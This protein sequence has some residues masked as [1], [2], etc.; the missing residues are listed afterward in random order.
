MQFSPT[1]QRV[2]TALAAKFGL[3]LAGAE[4]HLRIELGE[5]MMPLVIEVLLPNLLSVAHY[6]EQNGDLIAD[7]DVE[8]VITVQGWAPT[9]IRSYF[10]DRSYVN[11]PRGQADLAAFCETWAANIEAQGYG[12]RGRRSGDDDGAAGVAVAA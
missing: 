8:F 2:I 1:M 5:S 4:G 11:N 6:Y 12:T 9:A 3:D 10:G 7:P